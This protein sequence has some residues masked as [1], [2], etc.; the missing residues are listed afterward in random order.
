MKTNPY[1]LYAVLLF[2]TGLLTAHAT[3]QS[4]SASGVYNGQT[5]T[6]TETGSVTMTDAT[7]VAWT[8]NMT[9]TG[10]PD[11]HYPNAYVETAISSDGLVGFTNI[12]SY[13]L[14]KPAGTGSVSYSTGGTVVV[15]TGT[16][17][18]RTRINNDG[19][20]TF[21]GAWVAIGPPPT[22]SIT[23]QI[24]AV[25]SAADGGTVVHYEIRD[26]A[27]DV[28][29]TYNAIPGDAAT[30]VTLNGLTTNDPLYLVR[31]EGS[32][33]TVTVPG[34]GGADIQQVQFVS[35]GAT[36]ISSGTPTTSGTSV[37]SPTV[38]VPK[39]PPADT[40][41]PVAPTTS[42]TP[43]TPTTTTPASN[44][45]WGSL[46]SPTGT[47]G[48]TQ[49]DIM[50]AANQ[51]TQAVH[52][53]SDKNTAATAV[54][55]TAVDKVAAA[56]ADSGTKQVTAID[57]TSKAIWDNSKA[58]V[59]A[60][61]TGNKLLDTL[62]TKLQNVDDKTKA[63]G[64]KLD[65]INA[66]ISSVSTGIGALSGGIAS[67]TTAVQNG[68]DRTGDTAAAAAATASA[69]TQGA[70]AGTAASNAVTNAKGLPNIAPSNTGSGSLSI[71]AGGLGT[72]D[73]D[74]T[75]DADM[76]TVI[77][78]IKG[79]I[80]WCVT[81]AFIWW[82]WA[83]FRGLAMHSMLLPQAKGNTVAAGTGGQATALVAATAISVVLVALPAAFFALT[84]TGNGLVADAFAGASGP[85]A[86][87]VKLL[88]MLLPVD[89][90]VTVIVSA[91]A[92][93]KGG[94]VLLA[95]AAAVIRYI[96]P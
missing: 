30:S 2:I 3:S 26:A 18:M 28:V 88:Y 5:Y 55:V 43:T 37:S 79:F 85:V 7:H 59:G 27:G 80:A 64:T 89:T 34:A 82:L 69:N 15:P 32:L 92:V 41:T 87:G 72:L 66:G 58:I 35:T 24:A 20:G 83:E 70:A 48:A 29:S 33:H 76:M 45:S 6:T 84:S 91:F 44:G 40:P 11:S 10:N 19:L 54:V 68:P 52:D 38:P 12:G 94:L 36:P 1:R 47:S 21:T 60:V 73:L 63:N 61:D 74:P 22:Y 81:L 50:T 93:R 62:N 25:P 65:S 17:Y 71:T 23:F 95:G 53:A 51:I 67:L 49:T 16:A 9:V 75:H 42:T 96:V 31:L 14:F 46:P 39:G 78:F 4:G 77:T 57:K 8:L 13:R 56:V 90:I 86:L